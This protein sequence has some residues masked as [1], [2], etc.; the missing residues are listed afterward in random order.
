MLAFDLLR[1]DRRALTSILSDANLPDDA[2]II[3]KVFLLVCLPDNTGHKEALFSKLKDF[4]LLRFRIFQLNKAF[5]KP[6]DALKSLGKHQEK[7]TWQIHRIYRFRNSIIHSGDSPTAT[8]E[9]VA[10]AHDYFDQV[11]GLCLDL[12]SG[13]SGFHTFQESFDFVNWR[14]DQYR[15]ELENIGILSLSNY[16][17][18]IW[19]T[20][21]MPKKEH[22]FNSSDA[23]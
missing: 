1:W 18:V 13:S 9:L 17:K 21:K 12:C 22:F 10:G 5:A 3:E 20:N 16:R 7:L 23:G 2:D 15:R 8:A 6:S 4:E 11:F 19:R 14:E